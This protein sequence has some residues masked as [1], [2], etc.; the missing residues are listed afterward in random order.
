MGEGQ[1]RQP[2]GV[3]DRR[4]AARRG[5]PRASASARCSSAST[6]RTASCATPGA[7]AP[8]SPRRSSTR[9]ARAL[10]ARAPAT[11]RSTRRRQ[12]RRAAPSSASRA[13]GRDRVHASGR[14]R[15]ACAIPPTRAC[16]RTSAASEVV[17]EDGRDA[18]TAERGRPST[19][20]RCTRAS[21][22]TATATVDGRELKLSNLDKVLYP[23]AGFTKRDVIDYYARS[24]RRSSPTSQGRPLTVKRWPDGVDGQ[25]LLREAGARA[26]AGLGAD[27]DAAAAS[28]SRSTTCSRDDLRD[29]RVARQPRRARTAR[30]ARARRRARAP[31]GARVR[32][33]SRASPRRSI[34]CCR[35]ALRLHG[36]F[37]NLG[38]AELRQD[39]GLEGPAAVRAAQ[40]ARASP[41]SRPSRSPKPSRSCSSSAEPELVV[42]RMTKARRPGK[43]LI[44][45]SQNDRRKT[46]VCVYSLRAG[47]RPTVSTPRRVGGGARRARAPATRPPCS[48]EAAEV[49][50]RVP[51]AATCSRPSLR[52]CSSCRRPDPGRP[53]RRSRSRLSR[54]APHPPGAPSAGRRAS[55]RR[56][57]RA[58]SSAS[59]RHGLNPT[60]S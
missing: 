32:P 7:S 18:A 39:V 51:S 2:P 42:S 53:A 43:V 4:L 59:P 34:E 33:R 46:T 25:V 22:A 8:A 55:P 30:A 26:P 27:G 19:R 16:A 1:E 31:D 6:T 36:M 11:R 12:R 52:S 29:A 48:F 10:A 14:A 5:S 13:G 60:F 49:L 50:E 40:H 58:R 28:A 57:R 41:T 17:R 35:V 9:L 23:E 47:E 38:L 54:S 56:R 15:A 21:G 37:E 20:G 24:R 44:D 45:W 3:R